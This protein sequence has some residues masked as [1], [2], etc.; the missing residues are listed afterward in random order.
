MF[1]KFVAIATVLFAFLTIDAN[2][3]T[4][5]CTDPMATNVGTAGPCSYTLPPVPTASPFSC[6]G[7]W[8]VNITEARLTVPNARTEDEETW[9]VGDFSL[10]AVMTYSNVSPD[11]FTTCSGFVSG[12][13]GSYIY[14]SYNPADEDTGMTMTLP[15]PMTMTVVNLRSKLFG[16]SAKMYGPLSGE[17]RDQTSGKAYSGLLQAKV[18]MS[19][20]G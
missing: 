14:L 15:A 12:I 17:E 1:K 2:A 10:L 7:D 4:S 9:Y 6:F 13:P 16:D 20:K 5:V 18:V 11:G 19:H 8:R 3:Q